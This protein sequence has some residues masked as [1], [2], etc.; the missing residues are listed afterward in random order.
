MLVA[1]TSDFDARDC[2]SDDVITLS[3]SLV[4]SPVGNCIQS[5]ATSRPDGSL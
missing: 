2:S 5:A 4:V 1:S 3:G